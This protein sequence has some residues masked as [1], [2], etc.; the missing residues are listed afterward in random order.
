MNIY[1]II[2]L[3]LMILIGAVLGA[4]TG[5]FENM[6]GNIGRNHMHDLGFDNEENR[7][8]RD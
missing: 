7:Q 8:N 5:F 1:G 2:I 4:A 3:T 6:G